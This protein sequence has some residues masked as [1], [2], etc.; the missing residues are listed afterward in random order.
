VLN[1]I[2]SRPDVAEPAAAA[3]AVATPDPIAAG[4]FVLITTCTNAATNGSAAR[5]SAIT[6]NAAFGSARAERLGVLM[7]TINALT[8]LG[9]VAAVGSATFQQFIP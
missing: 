4:T 7:N 5:T 1:A 9:L 8:A 6:V 2:P 3:A